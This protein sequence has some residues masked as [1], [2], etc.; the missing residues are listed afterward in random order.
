MVMMYVKYPLSLRNVEDLLHQRGIDVCHETVRFAARAG[1]TSEPD[2][3][4]G[5]SKETG[6]SLRGGMRRSRHSLRAAVS[7]ARAISTAFRVN[8]LRLPVQEG[9]GRHG[10]PVA[11]PLGLAGIPHRKFAARFAA[12]FSVVHRCRFCRVPGHASKFYRSVPRPGKV[13]S[14]VYPG[15]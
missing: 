12:V 1:G 15:L 14:G 9:L 13:K 2:E 5:A 3:M 11:S 7:P 8:P 4:T 10:G 6:R